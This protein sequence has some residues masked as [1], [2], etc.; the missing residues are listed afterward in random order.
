MDGLDERPT[1]M[2]AA[3]CPPGAAQA[4]A[5]LDAQPL[6]SAAVC[7]LLD[8]CD[9]KAERPLR[10]AASSWVCCGALTAER[11]ARAVQ[12]HHRRVWCLALS[13]EGAV[14]AIAGDGPSLSVWRIA[15]DGLDCAR[16]GEGLGPGSASDAATERPGG[17]ALHE[18]S[19]PSQGAAA[20]LVARHGARRAGVSGWLRGGAG[21]AWH[22]AVC[23]VAGG[24]RVALAAPG[25]PLQLL[26]CQARSTPEGSAF[27]A[28]VSSR[29][30]L[31]ETRVEDAVLKF[32]LQ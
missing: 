17:G 25:C 9:C 7:S 15:R 12:A 20:S 23:S 2:R 29:A 19:R 8:C 16:A 13:P 26:A 3:G 14:A 11:C 1:D 4:A 22:A 5:R 28:P 10:L 21:G 24:V 6:L 30:G 18:H 32:V 31:L 27:A